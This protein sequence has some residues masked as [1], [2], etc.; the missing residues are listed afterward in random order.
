MKSKKHYLTEAV[1]NGN[2]S[3]DIQKDKEITEDA[4]SAMKLYSDTKNNESISIEKI[5]ELAKKY[6][7][8]KS[9]SKPIRNAMICE[10]NLQAKRMVINSF[11]H[12]IRKELKKDI[13]KLK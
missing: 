12:F 10:T 4:L 7:D 9:S 6:Y 8:D 13:L 1:I 2:N 11:I 5:S 3:F